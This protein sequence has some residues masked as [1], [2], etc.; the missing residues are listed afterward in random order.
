MIDRLAFWTPRSIAVLGI[1]FVSAFALDAFAPELSLPEQLLGFTIH[2]VPSA[3]LTIIL[4]V[5]WRFEAVGGVLFLAISIVPF[6]TLPNPL[7]VNFTLAGPFMI[8]G[9]L[10]LIS[11]LRRRMPGRAAQRR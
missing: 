10:F 3:V 4:A 6:L 5:G 1:L 7:W 8:A 11:H 2:L 9:I